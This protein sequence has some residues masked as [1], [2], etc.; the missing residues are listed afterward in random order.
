METRI[1]HDRAYPLRVAQT[2][3]ALFGGLVPSQRF[4]RERTTTLR[5]SPTSFNSLFNVSDK[6]ATPINVSS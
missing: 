5:S 4:C 2:A 1:F 3:T 6:H